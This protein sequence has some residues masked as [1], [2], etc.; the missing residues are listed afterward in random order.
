MVPWAAAYIARLHLALHREARAESRIDDFDRSEA[1]REVEAFR[2]RIANDMKDT[3][4]ALVRDTGT[5]IDEQAPDSAF[6]EVGIDEERI[7]FGIAVR[8]RH[9]RGESEYHTVSLRHEDVTLGDLFE[10][11]GDRIRIRKQRVAIAGIRQRGAPLQGLQVRTLVLARRPDEEVGHL[12]I[13][14][15]APNTGHR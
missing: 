1:A 14:P 4:G 6:P 2:V 9:D 11:K 3:R 8:T 12:R 5:V 15:I 10:R 7:E 13:L